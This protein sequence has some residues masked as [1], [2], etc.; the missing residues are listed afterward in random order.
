MEAFTF[1][2]EQEKSTHTERGIVDRPAWVPP[3]TQQVSFLGTPSI[4]RLPCRVR[5]GRGEDSVIIR[6]FFATADRQPIRNLTFLEIGAFDGYTESVTFVLEKCFGWSGILI[7]PHPH[8]FQRLIRSGR[9]RAR[10]INSAVCDKNMSVHMSR[11]AG[12][13]AKIV[14]LTEKHTHR[15]PC[16]RL[17]YLMRGE[18]RIDFLSIDVEGS[19]PEAV[20]SLQGGTTSI[21]VVMAE[22]TVGRRRT[23]TMKNLLSQ[24]FTYVGLINARPSPSNYVMSDVFV[25]LTHFHR[26]IPE[27]RIVK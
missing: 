16:D 10:F 1:I 18:E 23:D 20:Q 3:L 8:T 4:T 26:F 7:E 13:P 6:S 27:S 24:G 2:L 14:Q 21:G 12:T 17:A 19:E 22:V 25:N 9:E 15:I 11:A 5:G